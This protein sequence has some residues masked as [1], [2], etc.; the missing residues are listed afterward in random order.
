MI[1]NR[2]SNHEISMLIMRRQIVA[3]IFKNCAVRAEVNMLD[4]QDFCCLDKIL[5]MKK[6]GDISNDTE[7]EMPF[8]DSNQLDYWE[9]LEHVVQQN[10]DIPIKMLIDILISLEE[11]KSKLL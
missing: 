7:I 6:D 2:I 11:V 3:K 1:K 4:H 8:Y 5:A 9:R 10:E